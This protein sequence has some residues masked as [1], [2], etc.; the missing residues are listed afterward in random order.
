MKIVQ[1]IKAFSIDK[2][3]NLM[4]TSK[5]S[6]LVG[7]GGIYVPQ[8]LKRGADGIMTGFAFT[9]MLVEVYNLFYKEDYEKGE[10]LFD[11]YLP[12]IRHEQQFGVG[13][14][15]RKEVLK[16]IGV[17]T[18]SKVRAPG[19]ILDKNDFIELD[20]LILRLKNKLEERKIPIPKGI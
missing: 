10:D 5:F 12:L 8:E 19:P 9:Q 13:L 2:F 1:G 6:I 3:R 17:I 4:N 14:A 7:N 16:L 18:S 15:I 20:R 11:L